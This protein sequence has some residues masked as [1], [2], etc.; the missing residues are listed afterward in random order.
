MVSG[1][2]AFVDRGHRHGAFQ[3]WPCHSKLSRKPYPMHHFYLLIVVFHDPAMLV[4]YLPNTSLI[5]FHQVYEE[6]FIVDRAVMMV[7]T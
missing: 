2:T 6:I 4:L 3:F 1:A 7:A 5:S